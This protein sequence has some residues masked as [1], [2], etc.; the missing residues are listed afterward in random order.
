MAQ[1]P[2]IPTALPHSAASLH[3]HYGTPWHSIPAS[4]LW[5]PTEQH[6]CILTVL[7]HSTASL[8][9]Y[10][11]VQHPCIP[12]VSSHSTAS[13]HPHRVIPQHSIPAV[14]PSSTS[15][16]HPHNV[17]PQHSTPASTQRYPTAQHPCCGTQQHSMPASPPRYPHGTAPHAPAGVPR[18]P[19]MVSLCLGRK[20]APGSSG[21]P[22]E[23]LRAS[24]SP[25]ASP[26]LPQCPAQKERRVQHQVASKGESGHPQHGG[27]LDRDIPLRQWG[28]TWEKS[29]W[30]AVPRAWLAASSSSSELSRALAHA[31]SWAW[32]GD[33]DS[34]G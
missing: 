15:S 20:G 13:L 23:G 19:A 33:R 2:C 5:Y 11:A 8:L 24:P 10:P 9:W 17:T 26:V 30:L 25:T 14:V 18:V 28:R 1:H 3:P 27:Q 4:P 32:G 31:A 7:P 21:I 22:P 6:P 16:L 29:W 34:G 12:T